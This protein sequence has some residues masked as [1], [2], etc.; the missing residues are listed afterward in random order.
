MLC[1][2]IDTPISPQSF[3]LLRQITHA[4]AAAPRSTFFSTLH[5]S[6]EFEQVN[7]AVDLIAVAFVDLHPNL[8]GKCNLTFVE[9]GA[10]CAL[11]YVRQ[12]SRYAIVCIM[13]SRMH[14]R[15]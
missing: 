2:L 12:D 10:R 5:Y 1:A 8:N 7:D 14:A 3:F 11:P 6:C 9:E 4:A 15:G 13:Q